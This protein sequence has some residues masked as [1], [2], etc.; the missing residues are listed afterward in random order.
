MRY[1]V[2]IIVLL[3]LTRGYCVASMAEK[4]IVTIRAMSSSISDYYRYL[5]R[6]P[7]HQS[8]I[9]AFQKAMNHSRISPLYFD[10]VADALK[11]KDINRRRIKL[12]EL[13]RKFHTLKP[14]Y[15]RH[16]L[17]K[18]LG[19]DILVNTHHDDFSH[20]IMGL[21]SHLRRLRM[22]P[23]GEDITLFLNHSKWEGNVS[24]LLAES[25]YFTW[26]LI[27]SSWKPIVFN[28]SANDAVS[29]LE[30]IKQGTPWIRGSS[31]SYQWETLGFLENFNR[32]IFWDSTLVTADNWFNP[33]PLV[34]THILTDNPSKSFKKWAIAAIVIGSLHFIYQNK[35]KELIIQF[36]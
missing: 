36:Q 32:E 7:N 34:A 4:N 26:T 16:Q 18:S 21:D 11:I 2:S 31:H 8:P 35:N 33:T 25:D 24:E 29:W 9:Q 30:N 20:Q 10:Q 12:L 5:A 15:E 3:S 27:S 22:L 19:R 1:C 14:S 13:K 28:G 6:M 17:I 23:G